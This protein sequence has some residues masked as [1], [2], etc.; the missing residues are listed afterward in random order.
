MLVAGRT[1]NLDLS[2]R[3]Q[4]NPNGQVGKYKTGMTVVCHNTKSDDFTDWSEDL[5][6]AQ[7][8]AFDDAKSFKGV[9]EYP[10]Y[11]NY[12]LYAAWDDTNLYLGW[13]FV[14]VNDIASPD[15]NG[16]N[17]AKPTNGDIPQ[18][19]VFDID[20]SKATIGTM[21]SGKNVWYDSNPPGFNFNLSM[22]VDSLM[23]FSS[24]G[25]VGTPALFT[26]NSQGFLDYTAANCRKFRQLGIV[27][28]AVD[29]CLPSQVWGVKK[30][31][32][33]PADLDL[34]TDWIDYIA[35]KHNK[36]YDQFYEMK[37][38]FAALG[39]T[40]SI[41][42]TRGIGVMHV[43]IYGT[44]GVDSLPHDP[45]TLDNWSGSYAQDSSTSHEKDDLDKFS[46]KLA[47]IGKL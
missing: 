16:G 30:Y 10:S 13:Q 36:G 31:P 45:T 27:Y 23:M 7:G 41:L 9:W 38:P 22:G 21:A 5:L 35:A 1:N 33:E 40:R 6:I 11:D 28:G 39:I 25:G 32:Y 14:Y 44:S 34:T 4:T 24:K 43:S 37:I 15:N 42:E 18:M 26:M 19:L 47:R 46:V 8:A 17:E 20:P 3:Y 29:G 12:A 2:Q